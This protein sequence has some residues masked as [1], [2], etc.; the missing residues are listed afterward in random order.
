MSFS[1]VVVGW[2]SSSTEE[3]C[4]VRLANSVKEPM[5]VVAMPAMPTIEL[6]SFA[7]S[8]LTDRSSSSGFDSDGSLAVSDVA[9]TVPDD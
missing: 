5:P 4:W 1:S 9:S 2:E 6:A 8:I 7:K 3:F